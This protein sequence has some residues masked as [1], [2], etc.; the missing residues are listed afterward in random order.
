MGSTWHGVGGVVGTVVEVT[1]V[2]GCRHQMNHGSLDVVW[3]DGMPT[4][5]TDGEPGDPLAPLG[6]HTR[7]RR[8]ARCVRGLIDGSIP[9]VVAATIPCQQ[10]PW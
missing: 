9:Y 2:G 5:D 10:V 6:L 1:M 7:A 8:R 3:G 4:H